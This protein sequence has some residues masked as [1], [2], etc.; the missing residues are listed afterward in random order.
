LQVRFLVVQ[1]LDLHLPAAC[2][3]FTIIFAFH[4]PGDID[5]DKS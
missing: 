2:E 4:G 1:Y 3:V 5:H